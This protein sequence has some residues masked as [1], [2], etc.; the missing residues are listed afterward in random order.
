MVKYSY[1]ELVYADE[2]FEEGIERVARY[3]Y[4]G[5]EL[6]G[7]D[8]ASVDADEL[9]EPLDRFD[10]EVSSL[11]GIYTEERDLSSPDPNTRAAGIRYLKECIDLAAAVDAEIVGVGPSPVN[12]IYP[13]ADREEEWQLA[14][15]SIRECADYAAK[16][17]VVLAIEP[18]NRYET[19]FI[20]RLEQAVT[21]A[22]DVDRD[23][24]GIRADLFHMNIEEESPVRALREA[25]DHLVHVHGAGTTR[26]APGRGHYDWKEVAATLQAIG[27]DGYITFELLPAAADPFRVLEGGKDEAAAFY[28]Q[29]TEEAIEEVRRAWDAAEAAE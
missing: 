18:W 26:A 20:N 19:Y 17:G 3:G 7:E 6:A 2:S 13:D 24:V 12:K 29:Y 8:P 22:E 21:L 16:E 5:I 9:K 27:Y 11:C 25:R 14:I 10:V 23:N 1:N 4:E 28:D 15:D